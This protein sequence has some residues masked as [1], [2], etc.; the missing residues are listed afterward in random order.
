MFVD[1]V[2]AISWNGHDGHDGHGHATYDGHAWN[3]RRSV[4]V[5]TVGALRSCVCVLVQQLLLELPCRRSL[6][7]SPTS[8]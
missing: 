3:A 5:A 2:A 1:G 6:P 4:Y 7:R 8:L